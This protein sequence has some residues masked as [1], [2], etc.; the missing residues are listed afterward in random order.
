MIAVQYGQSTTNNNQQYITSAEWKL[1]GWPNPQRFAGK[2]DLFIKN[3]FICLRDS[4]ISKEHF[5]ISSKDIVKSKRNSKPN[6]F[7]IILNGNS[8]IKLVSNDSVEVIAELFN[9]P[10]GK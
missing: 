7:T 4:A 5:R 6:H 8:Y 3:E 9:V 10:R 1:P 2:A